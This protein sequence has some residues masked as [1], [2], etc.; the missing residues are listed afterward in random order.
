MRSAKP[1]HAGLQSFALALLVAFAAAFA[2]SPGAALAQEE[3]NFGIISTESSQNLRTIWEPFLAD[4]EKETGLK[5]KAF[6]AT[7]YAGIIEGMRFGK[8]QL[9]W[10]GNKSAIEAVDRADGEVFAQTVA[11]DGSEGYYSVLIA[12]VSSP[13]SSLDDMWKEAANLSFS[14]GDPNSTSGY[15]V[16][17]YYV[18]A[19]NGK[20]PKTAFKRTISGNHEANALAV[21]QG[22][23]DVATCNTENLG[24]LEVTAPD[25]RKQIKVIWTSPLIPSDPLVWRKDLDPALKKK[26]TDFLFGY[27]QGGDARE[28]GIL[29]ALTWRG[30]KPSSNDQ[31]I[32]IR[33]LELFKEKSTLEASGNL[34]D[35]DRKRL[36]E[37]ETELAALGQAGAGK[38]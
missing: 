7:D 19:A 10:Y 6:F 23:V 14:N 21:A 28:Q 29:N 12:N 38:K 33:Q 15:L 24:R 5:I 31:L 34:S 9:A 4:M 1:F 36:A 11:A 3:I 16:P 32:P 25:R 30:F 26:I 18:F 17:G 35:S 2:L 27:G 8:V 37:I 20:D 13:L 22:Q